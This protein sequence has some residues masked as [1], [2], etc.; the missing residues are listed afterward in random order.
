MP[1]SEAGAVAP[2]E[3]LEITRVFEAPR[4]LLFRLWADPAHRLRWWGPEGYG[5]SHCEVDFREGGAW[6]IAMRN[7]DGYEHRV[8]GTFTEIVEPRRL[9]FTYINDNDGHEMEVMMDFIDLGTRTEMRF[10]QA[11]FAT[12]E[13]RDEHGWG[14]GSTFGLLADYV[15]KVDR[16]EPMPVGRPRIDGVA[17]DIIAARERQQ[18]EKRVA[19][20]ET[21]DRKE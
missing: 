4:S 11:R 3:V 1:S 9:A 13:D 21:R 15:L 16:V 7:V 12:I 17:A 2:D 6:S 18:F 20:G 14:W 8:H 5:L 10:R 19:K